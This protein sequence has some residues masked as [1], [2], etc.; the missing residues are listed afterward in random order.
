MMLVG[1]AEDEALLVA[2]AGTDPA[3]FGTLYDRYLPSIYRYMYRRCGNHHEAEDL[4]SQTFHRALDRLPAFEWR[5]A[6]F[7]AWLFRIAHNLAIDWARARRPVGSLDGLAER[8]YEPAGS[9][10]GDSADGVPGAGLEDREALDAAWVAVESLP[11]MQRRAVTLYFGQGLSHAETG[12]EIG[13]SEAA[14]KQLVYRAV[15]TLRARLVADGWE[16]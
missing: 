3:A 12:K 2:R 1:A 7:G 15:K 16:G 5:G 11:M 10:A 9:D 8:G 4:T 14:T 6:P 13:R